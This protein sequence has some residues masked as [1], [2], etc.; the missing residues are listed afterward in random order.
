[1]LSSGESV[2]RLG[3]GACVSGRAEGRGE[4]RRRGPENASPILPPRHQRRVPVPGPDGGRSAALR[5]VPEPVS[6]QRRPVRALQQPG[7]RL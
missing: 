5:R 3:Q 2:C 4:E 1:M 6:G 7:R